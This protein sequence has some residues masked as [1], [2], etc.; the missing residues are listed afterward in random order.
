MRYLRCLAATAFLTAALPIAAEASV[1]DLPATMPGTPNVQIAA[2]C[3]DQVRGRI[4][5]LLS[6]L[7]RQYAEHSGASDDR[8][9]TEEAT[10]VPMRRVQ[11][12]SSAY[13]LFQTSRN[14]A[15]HMDDVMNCLTV[16]ASSE[17][18]ARRLGYFIPD[19]R[20]P[21]GSFIYT[22]KLGVYVD[23]RAVNAIGSQK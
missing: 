20:T 10:G 5:T 21:I 16:Y 15:L 1:R 6:A 23:P 18:D 17:A 19:N 11:S 14:G 2:K 13:L 9:Y 8:W 4:V 12:G 7:R 3:P 22:D